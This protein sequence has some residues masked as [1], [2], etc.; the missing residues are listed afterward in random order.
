[1]WADAYED[2]QR[3]CGTLQKLRGGLA[4]RRTRDVWTIRELIEQSAKF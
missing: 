1:M 3:A 4:N 2:V